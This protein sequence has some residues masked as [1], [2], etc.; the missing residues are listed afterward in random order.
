MVNPYCLFTIE[1]VITQ[2]DR[3]LL[4]DLTLLIQSSGLVPSKMPKA[5][6][7][8]VQYISNMRLNAYWFESASKQILIIIVMVGMTVCLCNRGELRL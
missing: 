5:L 4:D 2:T 1:S 8:T 6:Y 7:A 3:Q